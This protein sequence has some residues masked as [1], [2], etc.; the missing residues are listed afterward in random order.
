MI[1]FWEEERNFTEMIQEKL[2]DDLTDS[3][4]ALLIVLFHSQGNLSSPYKIIESDS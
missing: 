1:Q 4:V 3:G 2:L